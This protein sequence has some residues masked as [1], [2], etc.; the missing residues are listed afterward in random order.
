M[1]HSVSSTGLAASEDSEPLPI[2]ESVTITENQTIALKLLSIKCS[3]IT[4]GISI[5]ADHAHRINATVNEV[6]V[7]SN[8]YDKTCIY[9]G[10]VAFEKLGHDDYREPQSFC[11]NHDSS[12]SFYS[13]NS[14]MHVMLY[15][16]SIYSTITVRLNITQIRCKPVYIDICFYYYGIVKMPEYGKKC[17]VYLNYASQ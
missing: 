10:L 5:Q 2:S 17:Q 4:C 8:I 11:D 16:Y 12:K 1:T 6:V 9:S 3:D 15:W 13:N 14:T 7:M